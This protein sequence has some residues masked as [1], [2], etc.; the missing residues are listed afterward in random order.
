MIEEADSW[1]LPRKFKIAFSNSLEDTAY[2]QAT[3]LGFVAKL[4]EKGEKGF[5]VYTAGGMGA[6]PMVGHELYEFIPENKV[7]QVTKA[8]KIMFDK[9]GNR[10]SKYSSRIK[11]LWKKLD[12]E[13]FTQLFEE[14]YLKIRDDESLNLVLP[15]VKN[16]AK[17][18]IS[19]KP[20]YGYA[21]I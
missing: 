10:R 9:H 8:I 12:R 16:E 20:V 6:K 15:E 4:N 5:A 14:E 7:Y 3:C 13:E 17:A 2:T 21:F 19:I 18:E 1:N 11:F